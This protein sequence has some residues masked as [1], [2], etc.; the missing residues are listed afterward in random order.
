MRNCDLIG[1]LEGYLSRGGYNEINPSHPSHL[2]PIGL[3][4]G[5]FSPLL[6]TFCLLLVV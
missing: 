3:G 5:V 1:T 2:S 6:G 4:L